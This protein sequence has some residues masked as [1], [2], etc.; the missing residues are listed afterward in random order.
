MEEG[1]IRLVALGAEWLMASREL[2]GD[3]P[4]W[5]HGPDPVLSCS[6]FSPLLPLVAF[7]LFFCEPPIGRYLP[8]SVPAVGGAALGWAGL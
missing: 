7:L 5:P 8:P 6:L 3:G 2:R 4:F 1:S